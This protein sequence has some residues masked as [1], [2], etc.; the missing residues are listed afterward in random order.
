MKLSVEVWVTYTILSFIVCFQVPLLNLRNFL[1][2][3]ALQAGFHVRVLSP[4]I[5]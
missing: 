5:A 2:R 3:Y 1:G 4:A